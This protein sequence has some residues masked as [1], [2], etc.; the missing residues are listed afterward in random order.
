MPLPAP[1]RTKRGW[2]RAATAASC[3]GVSA[4]AGHRSILQIDGYEQPPFQ[5]AGLGARPDLA[6]AHP[7]GELDQPLAR[8]VELAFE[9]LL[10]AEVGAHV[11]AAELVLQP[12]EQHAPRAAVPAPERR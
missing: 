6:R 5:A 3:S 9:L 11:T 8:G 4:N 2:S 7:L 1:A 10:V 12:L